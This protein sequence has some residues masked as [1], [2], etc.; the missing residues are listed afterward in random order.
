MV[1]PLHISIYNSMNN[2]ILVKVLILYEKF[3][4]FRPGFII[5]L[6]TL[7]N[8]SP[9]FEGIKGC[10]HDPLDFSI[11]STVEQSLL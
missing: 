3:D 11:N 2:L 8:K 10:A 4:T 7:S 6:L 1:N 5:L 9:N